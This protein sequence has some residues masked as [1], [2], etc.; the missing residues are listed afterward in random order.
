MS[1]ISEILYT[2]KKGDAMEKTFT[3]KVIIQVFVFIVL[4]PFLPIFITGDWGWLEAWIYALINIFAFLISRVLAFKKHPDL[5]KERAKMTE[6]DDAK[7]WDKV[8]SRIVGL[9]GGLMPLMAGLD[10]RGGWSNYAFSWGW[11]SVAI[12]VIVLGFAFS[13]W[14]LLENRFFS[15]VVRIQTER[16]HHV[17]DGGPYAWVRHPGYA[18]ALFAYFAIPIL[19]DSL[20]TFGVVT[21]FAIVL[22]IRTSLEDRTLQAELPGYAEFTKRTRYRLFPGIW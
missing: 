16:G 18:G 6:H 4:I 14:A 12:L 5:L 22:I 8:L 21:L 13:T 20:Y 11:K 3:P 2:D 1:P 17:V 19:F 10:I 7:S 9:G 15:G